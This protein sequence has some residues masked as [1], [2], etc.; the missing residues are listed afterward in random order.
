[1]PTTAKGYPYP[2]D[3]AVPDVP[4]DIQALADEVN[5][6][7][8]KRMKSG[9]VTVTITASTTGSVNVTGL[10][11]EAAPTAVQLTPANNAYNLSATALAAGGFTINAR[12]IDGT[13][14]STTFTAYWTA[15]L[16]A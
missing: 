3:T 10:G 16:D 9:S 13:S 8:P 7:L 15:I 12:H 14:T 4:A 6:R 5:S 11:F 1:M 2:A